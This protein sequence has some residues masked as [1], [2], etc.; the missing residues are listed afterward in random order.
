MHSKWINSV[1]KALRVVGIVDIIV[2]VLC[3]LIFSTQMPE[4]YYGWIVFFVCTVSCA[5]SGLLF[6]GFGEIIDLL[7]GIKMDTT[8]QRELLEKSAKVKEKN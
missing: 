3:G 7:T 4:R 8:E 1:G 6:I 2:G 5:V